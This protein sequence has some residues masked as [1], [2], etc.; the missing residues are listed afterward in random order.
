[1][2]VVGSH[3]LCLCDIVL[4]STH[5]IGV[6]DEV[7]AKTSE[8]KKEKMLFIHNNLKNTLYQDC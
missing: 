4:I 3:L 6:S 1:M 8:G 7:R 5:N 2:Y